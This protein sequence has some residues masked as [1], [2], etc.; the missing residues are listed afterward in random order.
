ME[1]LGGMVEMHRLVLVAIEE[2]YVEFSLYGNDKFVADAVSMRTTMATF[3]HIEY[4]KHA[5]DV[6]WAVQTL[7]YDRE[8]PALV[9]H[10]L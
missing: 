5:L 8:L 7:L 9:S 10:V 2:R 6:K 1:S 3:R 4:P